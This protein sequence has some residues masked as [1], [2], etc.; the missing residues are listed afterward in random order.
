MY[1][2]LF[3]NIKGVRAYLI[4]RG[5]ARRKNNCIFVLNGDGES[6][7]IIYNLK[8]VTSYRY[9]KII[10]RSKELLYIGWSESQDID[11]NENSGLLFSGSVLVCFVFG[12]PLRMF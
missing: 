3:Y 1:L 7:L 12:F 2:A 5:H 11:A 8:E 6:I 10:L 9:Q 4:S